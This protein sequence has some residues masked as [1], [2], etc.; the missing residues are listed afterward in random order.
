MRSGSGDD[1]TDAAT[2]AGS[3]S[4][5]SGCSACGFSIYSCRCPC[6]CGDCSGGNALACADARAAAASSGSQSAGAAETS[7]AAE[8]S[9]AA[10]MSQFT[11]DFTDESETSA[12]SLPPLVC[13]PL[14]IWSDSS[15][16]VADVKLLLCSADAYYT[17][18]TLACKAQIMQP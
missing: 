15:R 6:D 3:A 10:T 7:P 11:E 13:M 18:S 5:G 12:E 14:K 4:D 1:A 2:R 17:A 9:P 8:N 16:N